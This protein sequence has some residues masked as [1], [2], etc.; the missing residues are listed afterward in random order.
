MVTHNI[1]KN[2]LHLKNKKTTGSCFMI[3]SGKKP[4]FITARHIIKK[5]K[6]SDGIEMYLDQRWKKIYLTTVDHH[7]TADVSVFETD[8]NIN[9]PGLQTSVQKI[10]QGQEVYFLGFPD[11]F[12]PKKGTNPSANN[13]LPMKKKA[14]ISCIIRDNNGH[15]LL[16]EGLNNPGFSGGPVVF[17]DPKDQTFKVAAIISGYKPSSQTNSPRGKLYPLSLSDKTGTILAYSVEN[18]MDLIRKFRL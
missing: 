8:L 9:L 2:V 13:P 7:P 17:Q 14:T 3:D 4:F 5:L 12:Q 16:L 15:Y 18:A 11:H 1:L 10:T 6:A